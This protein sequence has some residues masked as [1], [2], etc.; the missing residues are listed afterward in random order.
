MLFNSFEFFIFLPIVFYIY[1]FIFGNYSIILFL[2]KYFRFLKPIANIFSKWHNNVRLQNLFIVVSSYIFYGWWDCR[3]LLLIFFTSFCSWISGVL[4]YK[5]RQHSFFFIKSKVNIPKFVSITNIVL[6]LGIL[7]FFKYFNFFIQTFSDSITFFGGHPDIHTL[8]IILPIGISFYT[9]QALSYSIDVYRNK[10]TPTKDIVAFLAFVSF[11]PQL[12]AGPIERST[13]LLPQFYKKRQFDF[14]QALD[15]IW[16]IV[17]GLFKKMVIAD[18]CAT[19]VNH[20]W[21][22]SAFMNEN[23]STLIVAAFLFA[24]QI[25]CDFSGYSDIAIGTAKL[26]GIKLMINFNIPY[27]SRNIGEF[28]RRWHISLNKWFIDYLYIPI[29][30][31]RGTKWKTIRNTFVIFL[32]SGFWHGANWTFVSWGLFHALLFMPALLLGTNRKFLSNVV[33]EHNILPNLKET[34]QISKTF[35]LVVF[36]WIFFRAPSIRQAMDFIGHIINISIFSKPY[37]MTRHYFYPLLINIIILITTEYFLRLKKTNELHKVIL[38][39]LIITFAL[40]IILFYGKQA[41]FIYFQ[42]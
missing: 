33:A 29:G 14:N 1:W 21:N 20:V 24:F 16:L 41:T 11:F 18:N 28:W 42:F 27:F 39:S 7:G 5:Y 9:F 4:I 35:F 15:G 31:S 38:H 6:N 30:G 10:I 25:Y 17:W 23:A 22:N 8:Y 36:G 3:F 13:Q 2:S 32:V 34:W 37:I 12:V 40:L 26:F 19:Y